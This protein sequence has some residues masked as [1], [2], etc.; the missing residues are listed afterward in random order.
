MGDR[1]PRKNRG[2]KAKTGVVK[3][4][5]PPNYQLQT[6]KFCLRHIRSGFKVSD[7]TEGRD[8]SFALRLQRL[9]EH[10][11]KDLQQMGKHGLGTEKV[12]WPMN[13]VVPESLQNTSLW[14][15]R[16]TGDNRPMVGYRA[17]DVFHVVW[18]EDRF[19]ELYDHN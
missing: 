13:P 5:P 18:I 11:W 14:A 17:N 19:G 6:P 15:F 3:A 10:T 4:Q 16:Y 1:K 8:G 12:T 2:K 9:C 7:L